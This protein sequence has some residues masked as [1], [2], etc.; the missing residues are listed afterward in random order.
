MI[1]RLSVE[2]LTRGEGAVVYS[3]DSGQPY[4][5]WCSAGAR[6]AYGETVK[7]ARA[8]GCNTLLGA[9]QP[10]YYFIEPENIVVKP[11]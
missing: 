3:V 8:L 4:Q 5:R 2:Q 7:M 11:K 10:V 1:G 6:T 9:P